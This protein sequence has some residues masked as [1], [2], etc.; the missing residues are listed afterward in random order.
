MYVS[1]PRGAKPNY[2]M[3]IGDTSRT[4]NFKS[5]NTL[6]YSGPQ[7]GMAICDGTGKYLIWEF[8]DGIGTS[9]FFEL[10]AYNVKDLA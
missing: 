6:C 1:R 3:Y 9:G 8:K 5:D 7:E 10:L 2:N 4:G